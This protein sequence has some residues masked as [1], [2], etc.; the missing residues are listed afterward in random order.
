M[1]TEPPIERRPF[2]C[3]LQWLTRPKTLG[4]QWPWT[5]VFIGHKNSDVDPYEGPVP[6]KADQVQTAGVT[7][8]F[9]LRHWTDEDVWDYIETNAS[10][11]IS[12]A[13]EPALKSTTNGST[14]II[15]TPALYR[16]RDER[17]T[18]PAR[19]M[20]HLCATWGRL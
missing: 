2:V 14:P 6:L 12:G 8:V 15:S 3:G 5:T 11:T 20:A 10:L 17:K 4:G 9:P 1:N 7:A 19:N 13:T 18:V 16:S